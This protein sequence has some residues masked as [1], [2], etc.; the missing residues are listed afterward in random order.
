MAS[1]KCIKWRRFKACSGGSWHISTSNTDALVFI[2]KRDIYFMGIGAFCNYN[3]KDMTMTI[4][5]KLGDGEKSE[6]LDKLL[7]DAEKDAELKTHDI[8]ITELGA[9]PVKVSADDRLTVYI[10]L[11]ECDGSTA[12]RCFYGN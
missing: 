12:G 2:P 8:N 7:V 5:W 10:R 1:V 4:W 3:Q 9:S 11:K 6:E